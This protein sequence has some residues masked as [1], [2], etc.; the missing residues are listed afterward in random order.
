MLKAITGRDCVTH[1]YTST[2]ACTYGIKGAQ[3]LVFD[4]SKLCRKILK[5]IG[6]NI[7]ETG[8]AHV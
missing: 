7:K 1:I 8:E 2:D 6:R 3:H 4:K 5:D